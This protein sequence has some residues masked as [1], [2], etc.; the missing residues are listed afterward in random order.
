[1]NVVGIALRS[2]RHRALSTVLTAFGVALGIALWLAVSKGVDATKT[3]YFDAA[4]G[5]DLV[6]AGPRTTAHA[7]V[8]TAVF[9]RGRLLDTVPKSAY[10]DLVKDPRV[11]RAVPCA[12]GDSVGSSRVVGTTPQF[13]D[14][15]P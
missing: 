11:L 4:R 14:A 3:A 8:M 5:Y 12:V 7:A 10:E 15:I 6:I 13:F 1:M 9:H 2:L